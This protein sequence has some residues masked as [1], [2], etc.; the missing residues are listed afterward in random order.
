MKTGGLFIETKPERD[1]KFQEKRYKAICRACCELSVG[2]RMSDK[3]TLRRCVQLQWTTLD[4]TAALS[5]LRTPYFSFAQHSPGAKVYYPIRNRSHVHF[6]R[7]FKISFI[8]AL[9]RTA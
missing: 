7:Q 1:P 4:I 5:S 8:F 3:Q 2:L 9:K 6:K